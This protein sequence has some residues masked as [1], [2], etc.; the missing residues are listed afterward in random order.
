MKTVMAFSTLERFESAI[1]EAVLV[2][3]NMAEVSSLVTLLFSKKVVGDVYSP[4]VSNIVEY[5]DRV[6]AAQTLLFHI[7]PVVDR[8]QIFIAIAKIIKL[9]PV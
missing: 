8:K 7:V 3:F 9:I 1:D 6:V 4:S 5:F 2:E